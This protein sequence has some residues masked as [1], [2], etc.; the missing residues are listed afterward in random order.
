METQDSPSNLSCPGSFTTLI[1]PL[2]FSSITYWDNTAG[3]CHMDLTRS[4]RRVWESTP[5]SLLTNDTR[6][7]DFG[8]ILEGNIRFLSYNFLSNE[9]DRDRGTLFD[10]FREFREKS[11]PP[12]F[13]IKVPFRSLVQWIPCHRVHFIIV[14]MSRFVVHTSTLTHPKVSFK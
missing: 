13:C 1:S 14:G 7:I 8:Y 11:V 5:P 3:W 4:P 2:I 6:D 10:F 12:L 9:Q